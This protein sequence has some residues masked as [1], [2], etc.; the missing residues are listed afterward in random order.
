MRK[1]CVRWNCAWRL[2]TTTCLCGS[3][4][5]RDLLTAWPI[6]AD[7]VKDSCERYNFGFTKYSN[8]L[9]GFDVG[10][11]SEIVLWSLSV[12]HMSWQMWTLYELVWP[13]HI[14]DVFHN[15]LYCGQ[16]ESTNCPIPP[17]EGRLRLCSG[18]YHRISSTL[19]GT[20]RIIVTPCCKQQ[21]R[22]ISTQPSTLEGT[23]RKLQ[24]VFFSPLLT[25]V[26]SGNGWC[27]T[28]DQRYLMFKAHVKIKLP[29]R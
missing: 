24:D 8:F 25:I 3:K 22:R 19:E 7:T 2:G 5:L 4:G 20:T 14:Y 28:P 13:W 11:T 10:E 9:I 18:L 21:W 15:I 29:M 23:R 1:H 12:I 26:T 16:E 27:P 17:S 6:S